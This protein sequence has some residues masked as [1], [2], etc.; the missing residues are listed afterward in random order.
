MNGD[1]A[2]RFMSAADHDPVLASWALVYHYHN[3][4]AAD[5]SPHEAWEAFQ[6]LYN[7]DLVSS[8]QY[9]GA[10]ATFFSLSPSN[11][12]IQ[13]VLSRVDFSCILTEQKDHSMSKLGNP[14]SEE[15]SA[16]VSKPSEKAMSL[17]SRQ[18]TALGNPFSDNTQTLPEVRR[19]RNGGDL[20]GAR[21]A[22]GLS[23]QTP[24][25]ISDELNDEFPFELSCT[26]MPG[27]KHSP[28]L[29]SMER[30]QRMD[31]DGDG[32]GQTNPE[33][34]LDV[35]QGTCPKCSLLHHNSI[36]QMIDPGSL[37]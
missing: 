28:E 9:N 13:G 16:L 24:V 35:F 2:W 15:S 36:G 5:A 22:G 12:E 37:G 6:D 10:A 25:P 19:S 27:N 29:L 14:F 33:L 8:R 3:M 7:Y 34:T 26:G 1:D 17:P 23:C 31:H 18:S 30:I 11:S 20:F 21:E 4:I 32:D